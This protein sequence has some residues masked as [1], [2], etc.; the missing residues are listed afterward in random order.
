M[1]EVLGTLAA[2]A[3]DQKALAAYNAQQGLKYERRE[4]SLLRALD[5]YRWW[6]RHP[7]T[8]SVGSSIRIRTYESS[9]TPRCGKRNQRF[10]GCE[11]GASSAQADSRSFS[12]SDRGRRQ[13]TQPEVPC[14]L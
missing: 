1:E 6:C 10:N 13:S 3:S 4:S 2:D 7:T 8:G 11:M 9:N 14:F 12:A 5:A